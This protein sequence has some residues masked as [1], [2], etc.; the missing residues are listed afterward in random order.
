M[1]KKLVIIGAGSA[2]FT[3]GLVMDL[4]KKNPGGYKWKLSLVDIDGEILEDV[5]KLVTKM[6]QGKEADIELDWSTDR[7]DCLPGADYIVSTI[8]VGGRRAWEQDVFIPRKYGIYQPV[9]DTAMPGG[10]SRAMRMVPAMLDIVRDSMRLAPN[11]LFFNYSNP[12][13]IICRAVR[14]AL[15]YPITGLC[16]GTAGSEW[17]IADFMGWDRKQVTSLAAGINHCTFIYELRLNGKDAW[18]AVREKLAKVYKDAFESDIGDRFH[19][20]KAN[21]KLLELGEPWAWSFFQKYGAF[22]APGDRHV[23]EFF[24]EYFPGGSYYGKT[25]GVDAYSFEQTISWGDKIYEDTIKAARSPEPLGEEFFEHFHGEHEQLMDIIDS[26]ERDLR[27][28]FYM[29]VQNCGTI[30]NLPGWAVVEMP[31]VAGAN[32]PK[33][34]YL[35]NFPDVLAGFTMRFLS[36]IEIAVD[37]ALKGDR[38]LMEEAILSGGYI[39]DRNAVAKMVDELLAAHKAYLPQFE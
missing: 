39:S 13:A 20:E 18:P 9:G 4:I 37:A 28:I 38:R 6:I 17:Y 31:A 34:V 24:T 2:M 8:G 36:G 25:L 10:I 27:K 16:I 5:A 12:M 1:R 35:D 11:A 33:P 14:K 3:Q 32:G 22:P 19:G 29:N 23:T 26:I 30:P 7:C 21:E 15:N